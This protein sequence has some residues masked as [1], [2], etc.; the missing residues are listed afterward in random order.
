MGASAERPGSMLGGAPSSLPVPADGVEGDL[1]AMWRVVLELDD[2]DAREDFFDLGGHSLSAVQLFRRI[3]DTFGVD[4][5][6]AT[7]FEAP[8]IAELA[9]VLRDRI[10]AGRSPASADSRGTGTGARPT[11]LPAS[12]SLVAVKQGAGRT[13]LFVVHGAG[14]NVLN[15]KD[16]ARAMD[17]SQSVLGLQASGIDGVSALGETI[18]QMARTYLEDVRAGAAARAVPPG[19]ILRGRRHRVRNGEET[20]GGG[21]THRGAGLHRH[22]PPADAC[23]AHQ[24]VHPAGAS[25][26]GGAGVCPGRP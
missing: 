11:T 2:V 14:G 23:P 24:R 16:L 26:S 20:G 3:R 9:V 6:L 21:R 10:A 25:S 12:R 5:P 7:L 22:V 18:E 13:P 1:A 15:I 4:L 19:G 17:P 8:T